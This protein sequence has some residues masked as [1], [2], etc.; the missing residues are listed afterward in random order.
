MKKEDKRQG[1]TQHYSHIVGNHFK[2]LFNIKPIQK[3]IHSLTLCMYL[4]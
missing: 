3:T 4:K 2:W 1:E